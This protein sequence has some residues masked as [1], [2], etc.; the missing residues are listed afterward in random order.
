MTIRVDCTG[1]SLEGDWTLTGVSRNLDALAN[2]LQQLE[3]GRN[4]NLQVDCC[5]MKAADRSGLDL[6][7]VWLQC[8]RFRGIEPILIN[9]PERLRLSMQQLNLQQYLSDT[10]P[11]ANLVAV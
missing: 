2:S 5:R 1:A 4:K 10:F 8:A 6:L 11:G 3:S 7:N 9:V